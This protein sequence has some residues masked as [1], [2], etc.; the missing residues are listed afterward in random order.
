LLMYGKQHGGQAPVEEQGSFGN[1]FGAVR[2]WFR[3]L[4]GRRNN[5]I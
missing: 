2:H 3:N 5:W 4:W 1:F